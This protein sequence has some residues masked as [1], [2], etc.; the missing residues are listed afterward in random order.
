MPN[1]WLSTHVP[2]FQAM[3]QINACFGLLSNA[4]HYATIFGIIFLLLR[5]MKRPL[6]KRI[7]REF[8]GN[9]SRLVLWCD[10]SWYTRKVIIQ[11][12]PLHFGKGF[13]KHT[14][15]WHYYVTHLFPTI[16]CFFAIYSHMID[17]VHVNMYLG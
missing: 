15:Y 5:A 10:V 9:P 1:P 17:F 11:V 12:R 13:F 4:S 8:P 14:N 2:G 7:E 3:N 16:L 6:K